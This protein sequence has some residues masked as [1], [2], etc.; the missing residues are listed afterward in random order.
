MVWAAAVRPSAR[1]PVAPSC[2]TLS[3]RLYLVQAASR[4]VHAVA[5]T[6]GA[7]VA[8]CVAVE[9]AGCAGFGV[10]LA[11]AGA[12]TAAVGAATAADCGATVVASQVLHLLRATS[13]AACVGRGGS[14][15]ESLRLLHP[16]VPVVTVAHP[17]AGCG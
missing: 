6:T 2:S 16:V 9:V 1:T 14:Q 12:A 4:F 17:T 10:P 3:S 11:A 7:V 8:D 15:R 5:R 13:V